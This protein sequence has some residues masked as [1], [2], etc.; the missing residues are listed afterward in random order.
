V[1]FADDNPID[2]IDNI[3]RLIPQNEQDNH[4]GAIP[5]VSRKYV[6]NRLN[7]INFNDGTITVNLKHIK[8]ENTVSLQVKP[9]PCLDNYLD[10]RWVE[11][12]GLARKLKSFKYENFIIPDDQRLILAHAEL[13]SIS[14][15]GICFH[16]PEVCHVISSRRVKRHNSV[17]IHVQLIQNGAIFDGFLVDFNAVSFQV[18]VSTVPPQSFHWINPESPVTVIVKNENETLYSGENEI[19]RHSCGQ[20][21]RSYVL[22]PLHNQIRRFKPKEFRSIRH[23]LVP[24]PNIIFVDPF[25]KRSVNLKVIDLSGSGFSVEEDDNNS[26]LLPGEIIPELSIDFANVFQITC[27]AQ[28]IYR[29]PCTGKNWN[30]TVV[31]CGIAIIDMKL[32]DHVSLLGLL[33]QADNSNSYV[34]NKVDMDELWDF[35]FETGF[36]YPQK[37]SFIQAYKQKFQDTYEKLYTQNPNIAR[38]FIYQQNGTIYGHIAMVRF[39]QNTWL[40]QHHASRKTSSYKPGLLVLNQISRYVNEIHNLYSAHLHFVCC[41]F[42]PDNKFPKRVFGGVAK[43]INELKGC[44]IN[45]FAYL[46]FKN[47][48]IQ[49]DLSGPWALTK[50]QSVDLKELEHFY[51]YESGGL[52]LHAMDLEPGMIESNDLS[53]EY[54]R[55]GFKRERHLFSLKKDGAL[56]AV[57]MV[58]SSDIGLNMSDLTNCL[59]V[60][61]LDDNDLPKEILYMMLSLLSV[62][63]EHQEIPVLLYPVSYAETQFIPYEKTYA[64]WVLNLQYLDQYYRFCEKMLG[65]A[66]HD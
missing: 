56:K 32:E 39:Y 15:T 48:S 17:S 36:V 41:Y 64:F 35:F 53:K 42:R 22:K 19:I 25:T 3:H 8:Y 2:S 24:S 14:G 21:T 7:Y 40:I 1:R 60:I 63:F 30:R 52:M 59:K 37:Y 62:K 46:H 20:Q 4:N 65:P 50:T 51:E 33:Q 66:W 45:N 58:N 11:T 6:I 5:E 12:E 13:K 16:L 55:L 54:Q 38:Y 34:C 47:S 29:N 43:Y 61:V 49:W 10:C 9:Q 28:V 18:E 44:S 31:K 23:K 57:I 26:V 27:K